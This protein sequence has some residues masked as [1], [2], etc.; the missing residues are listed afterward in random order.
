MAYSNPTPQIQRGMKCFYFYTYSSDIFVFC[1]HAVVI[2]IAFGPL[3]YLFL[4]IIWKFAWLAHSTWQGWFG[5]GYFKSDF[6]SQY[7]EHTRASP[8][9]SSE[10][11]CSKSKAAWEE[12]AFYQHLVVNRSQISC[13]EVFSW[14]DSYKS[15][16]KGLEGYSKWRCQHGNT[17]TSQSEWRKLVGLPEMMLFA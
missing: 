12:P 17:Q 7:Q 4:Y 13:K 2:R 6:L 9:A 15:M 11:K 16:N 10:P 5:W 1:A 14:W 8:W 3:L